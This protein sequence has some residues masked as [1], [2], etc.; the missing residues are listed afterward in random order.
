MDMGPEGVVCELPHPHPTPHPP[1]PSYSDSLDVIYSASF[2]SH[3]LN[4][5]WNRN[6][7]SFA[8]F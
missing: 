3:T 5:Q 1:S 8:D 7:V 6:I 2:C 4:G